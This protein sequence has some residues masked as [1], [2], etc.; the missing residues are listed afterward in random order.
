MY[1]ASEEIAKAV[2]Y[3]KIR[4][5]TA[6][7]KQSPTPVDELLGISEPWSIASPRKLHTV[8]CIDEHCTSRTM[9]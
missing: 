2:N 3:P 4:V 1:N 7:L 6:A 9:A 8:M 5:F